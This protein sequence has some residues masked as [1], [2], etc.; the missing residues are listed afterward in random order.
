MTAPTFASVDAANPGTGAITPAQADSI[1]AAAV[2]AGAPIA[3]TSYAASGPISPGDKVSILANTAPA[4]MTLAAG[5]TDNR[6][7][8]I[9][10]LGS[11]PAS[12]TAVIDGQSQTINETRTATLRGAVTL[13]WL[14]DLATYILE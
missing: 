1:L 2:A 13:R 6:V 9:K 5:T 12:L 3:R 7:Q 11:A 4:A 14:A 10:W 8:V